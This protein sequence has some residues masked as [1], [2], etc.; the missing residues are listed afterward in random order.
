M[1]NR[2]YYKPGKPAGTFVLRR[3]DAPS[4]EIGPAGYS[5]EDAVIQHLLDNHPLK[6][7]VAGFVED[8]KAEDRAKWVQARR[9]AEKAKLTQKETK[10]LYDQTHSRD[11]VNV[12]GEGKP[13]VEDPPVT[14]NQEKEDPE[15]DN[16]FAGLPDD[17]EFPYHYGGGMYFLSNGE[18]FKGKKEEAVA[19]EAVLHESTEIPAANDTETKPDTSTMNLNQAKDYL[20]SKGVDG[21][22]LTSK[23]KIIKAGKELSPPAEFPELS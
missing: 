11:P 18:K 4:I 22:T 3:K 10:Q 6:G 19:A 17:T 9:K 13:I 8:P 12:D 15:S 16:K 2:K 14:K 23:E 20:I 7:H 21:R 5:T 1:A